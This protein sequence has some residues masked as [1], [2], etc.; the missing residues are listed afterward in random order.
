MRHGAVLA[1][2]SVMA[3]HALVCS[4]LL[5]GALPAPFP[6]PAATS[7]DEGLKFSTGTI[8]SVDVT[9]RT[10]VLKTAAGPATFDLK[11]VTVIGPDKQPRTLS[12]LAVGQHV[13]IYFHIGNG[14]VAQEIDF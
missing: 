4:L 8:V 2:R 10:A 13:S 12:D 7:L 11:Q 6:P 5:S 9:A 3:L 14:A 1:S